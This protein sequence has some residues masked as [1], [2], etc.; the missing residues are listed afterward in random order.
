MKTNKKLSR[1]PKSAEIQC[2]KVKEKETANTT[3]QR[4]KLKSLIF[5]SFHEKRKNIYKSSTICIMV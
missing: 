1:I 4:I 3:L 5:I 2:E